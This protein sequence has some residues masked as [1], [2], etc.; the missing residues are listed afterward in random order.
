MGI[1]IMPP[2]AWGSAQAPRDDDPIANDDA[3]D[4]F[5]DHVF[6]VCSR[7]YQQLV[8]H[9]QPFLEGRGYTDGQIAKFL[10][11]TIGSAC[12]AIGVRAMKDAGFTWENTLPKFEK[13]WRED[14]AERASLRASDTKGGGA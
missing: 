11:A 10:N 4:R 1:V 2:K 6:D 12:V 5:A 7:T 14:D 8:T 9:Y 13:A 3:G